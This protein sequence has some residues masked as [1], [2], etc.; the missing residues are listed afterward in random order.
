LQSGADGIYSDLAGNFAGMVAAHTVSYDEDS[1]AL[2]I[3]YLDMRV[4]RIF[5]LLPLPSDISLRRGNE[6]QRHAALPSLGKKWHM[7]NR[8]QAISG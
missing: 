3:V 7:H 2:L 6:V 4:T 1:R 5:I 8:P